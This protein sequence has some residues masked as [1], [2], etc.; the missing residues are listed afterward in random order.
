MCCHSLVY[1][2]NWLF[3]GPYNSLT[4]FLKQEYES[5]HYESHN[6]ELII[7]LKL[8]DRSQC[9]FIDDK[10][11]KKKRRF[12]TVAPCKPA[13]NFFPRGVNNACPSER[14]ILQ[15]GD[16]LQGMTECEESE[17]EHHMLK[18]YCFILLSS[19]DSNIDQHSSTM[20]W[21]CQQCIT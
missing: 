11:L 7:W 9:I 5:P 17:N 4:L 8:S 2:R 12:H 3:I 1:L 14:V 19:D 16:T 18:K 15:R 6:Q 13:Q 20:R 21:N 10:Q